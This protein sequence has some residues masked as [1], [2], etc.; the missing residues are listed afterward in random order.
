[1]LVCE[2]LWVRILSFCQILQEAS[3]PQV[4]KNYGFTPQNLGV[5][6]VAWK[7]E[8]LVCILMGV[9]NGPESIRSRPHSTK[10]CPLQPLESL[11]LQGDP[12]NQS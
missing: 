1:M 12:S 5:P 11:G 9:G 2:F 8:I 4:F 10:T 6:T 7:R 3:V